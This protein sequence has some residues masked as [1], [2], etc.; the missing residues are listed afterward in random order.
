MTNELEHKFVER[1]PKWFDVN[2]DIRRTLMPFGFAHNDG[3]FN[4][5][6]QLCLDIEPLIGDAPFEVLQVK[7]KFGGLRFYT[8][9]GGENWNAIQD[10]IHKAESDSFETC[11]ECGAKGVLHTTGYWVKT[12]CEPCGVKSNRYHICVHEVPY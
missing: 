12:L 9:G 11:E 5:L 3:W 8:A 1:W 4:L 6:W 2:G 7:E 10:R